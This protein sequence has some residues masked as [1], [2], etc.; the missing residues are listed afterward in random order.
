MVLLIIII[1]LRVSVIGTLYYRNYKKK[2]KIRQENIK[3]ISNPY[4]KTPKSGLK[5]KNQKSQI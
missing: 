5:K 1:I 2:P 4:K 3:K